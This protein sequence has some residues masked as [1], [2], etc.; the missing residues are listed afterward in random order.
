MSACSDSDS[1]GSGG[2]SDSESGSES[3]S[4]ATQRKLA[5][6]MTKKNKDVRIATRSMLHDEDGDDEEK[7]QRMNKSVALISTQWFNACSR[8][9]SLGRVHPSALRVR[10]AHGQDQRVA[11][12]LTR[13]VMIR[14]PL[15]KTSSTAT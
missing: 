2:G 12:D 1:I 8:R 11:G 4:P 6:L 5:K 10:Q 13:K 15:S 9:K 14:R 7:M 3:F